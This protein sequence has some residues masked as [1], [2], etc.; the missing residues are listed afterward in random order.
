MYKHRASVDASTNKQKRGR[1]W[2]AVSP[3]LPRNQ[4]LGG[5]DLNNKSQK[6]GVIIS[7]KSKETWKKKVCHFHTWKQPYLF[8]LDAGASLK[9]ARIAVIVVV[10]IPH[11]VKNLTMLRNCL[12]VF[13]S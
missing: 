3:R 9:M 1:E 4:D 11:C 2:S 10:N 6:K 7:S 13:Y 12:N 8:R 5:R